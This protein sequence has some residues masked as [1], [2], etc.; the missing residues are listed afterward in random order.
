M[1]L[2]FFTSFSLQ[3]LRLLEDFSARLTAQAQKVSRD[4]SSLMHDTSLTDAKIQSVTNYFLSL[5]D[6]QFIENV[7]T[8]NLLFLIKCFI[9]SG[10]PLQSNEKSRSDWLDI[11]WVTL[12][13]ARNF[14]AE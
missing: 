8:I 7:S 14:Y 2:S 10:F 13:F 9:N 6:T 5:S 3:L 4:V 11:F 12:P 1:K